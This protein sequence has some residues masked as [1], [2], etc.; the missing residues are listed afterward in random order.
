MSRLHKC[1]AAFYSIITLFSSA[2]PFFGWGRPP[3]ELACIPDCTVRPTGDGECVC[4]C[5]CVCV[6]ARARLCSLSLK[7]QVG[8]TRS[9][10]NQLSWYHFPLLAEASDWAPDDAGGS[11]VAPLTRDD[12]ILYRLR[13]GG[14]GALDLWT[15]RQQEDTCRRFHT[16]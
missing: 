9:V 8:E 10:F 14:G 15:R 13:R 16:S 12:A 1:A 6:C 2:A 3:Q 4:V 7:D 11:K 5:V